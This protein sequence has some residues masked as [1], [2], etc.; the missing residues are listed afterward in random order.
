MGLRDAVNALFGR[1]Q[2]SSPLNLEYGNSLSTI[3]GMSPED[4]FRTQPYLR[5]VITF[6]ARN[7]AQL[8]LHAFERVSDTDRRRVRDDPIVLLL[9]YPNGHMTTYDLVFALV[10]DLALYDEAIWLLFEDETTASGWSLEPLSP[11]W[12]VARGGGNAF[13]Y[14]WIEFQRPNTVEKVRI[15]TADML[16]FK[17]WNPGAPRSAASPVDAL[18][19]I[20]AEQISAGIFRE[21]LW[22]R[23]GR[24][25]GYLSRPQGASWG[26][27]TKKKFQEQW[28]SRYSGNGGALAGATP[29]L[30][31]GMT[32]T[33]VGHSAHEEEFVESAKLALTTVA[34]VYHVNPTMVG[35]LD[36]ANFSNVKEFRSMLYGDTLGSTIAMLEDGFNTFLVPRIATTPDLY[37]EFNIA[38]KLQGSFEE[39][40]AALSS[41][42]GAPWLSRNEARAR[43]NL[44]AIDGADELVTPLN[45]LVGG[46]ASPRDSA[47]KSVTVLSPSRVFRAI[48]PA[49][50]LDDPTMQAPDGRI[51]YEADQMRVRELK[52]DPPE[53]DPYVAKAAEVFATF[54]RRQRAVVLSRLG[55]KAPEW[56]DESRWD[57]ELSDDLYALSVNTATTL[58]RQQASDMGFDGS[59]Y[60]EARTLKFLRAVAD[61]RAG[62]VNST[63]RDRISAALEAE[64]D[65]AEVFDEAESARTESAAG[66][67]VAALAGF[68]VVEA[69]SQLV[70]DN[71]KKTWIT[72][73]NPRPDH[74]AMDGETVPIS[75]N[76]SNGAAWPG[77]PV[78]G[79]DGVAGCNCGVAVTF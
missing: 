66:A 4:L 53:V 40:A 19:Q 71:A 65:P 72:G 59:E 70:G 12:I 24:I 9:K 34:S 22:K 7:I 75:E 79:A 5:T 73:D 58:G 21:Q 23:G 29:I 32:Y 38:E 36:N 25:G 46:Q 20:L 27:D 28:Q 2:T 48:G 64:E 69:A 57:K 49:K 31:D 47:P 35:L 54:F 45:V 44:P 17:G 26:D 78:L 63:T 3:F 39:Q 6:L 50:S 77:D 1:N 51:T 15:A 55:A 14:E 43:Q 60:D 67:L 76:F 16:R 74:A 10:A 8:G 18:K 11:A 37:L 56:W 62:A 33:N 30:E 13:T 41:S 52:S 68:A 42:V 61:S